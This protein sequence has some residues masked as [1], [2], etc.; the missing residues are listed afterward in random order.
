MLGAMRPILTLLV[1]LYFSG[2]PP[3]PLSA[4][5]TPIRPSVE[6]QRSGIEMYPDWTVPDT[7]RAGDTFITNLPDSLAGQEI[8]RYIGVAL[9][10][11]SWLLKKSF[12]WKTRT[13]DRGNHTLWF[14]AFLSDGRTDSLNLSVVIE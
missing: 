7:V 6:Y 12:F 3:L 11:R 10:A 8:D 2:V 14:R 4:V 9:P 1:S 13:A 5:Q